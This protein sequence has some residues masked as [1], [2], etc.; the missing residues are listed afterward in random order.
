MLLT[1]LV[2]FVSFVATAVLP[3]MNAEI[4]MLG[5]LPFAVAKGQ[6]IPLTIAAVAGQMAGKAIIYWIARRGAGS[7]STPRV[8]SQVERWRHLVDRPHRAV[9]ILLVSSAVGFPP[10]YA[11]TILAGSLRMRF[12][13]FFVASTVGRLVHFGAIA[14]LPIV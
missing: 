7:L 10:L 6:L 8:A 3:W 5:L 12:R 11:L 13:V 14:L 1:F 9:P 4:L 2:W